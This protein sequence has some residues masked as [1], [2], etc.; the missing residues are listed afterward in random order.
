MDL[1]GSDFQKRVDEADSIVTPAA[2]R[3]KNLWSDYEY[4]KRELKAM[5]PE[6][7]EAYE[8]ISSFRKDALKE[9]VSDEEFER[10]DWEA[11]SFEK[12]FEANSGG[13]SIDDALDIAD[14][15]D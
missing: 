15:L 13:I 7:E 4:A 12:G 3:F 11:D 8:A 5:L 1:E 6:L 9:G 14:G 2:I 10:L